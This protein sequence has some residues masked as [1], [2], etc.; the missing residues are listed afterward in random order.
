MAPIMPGPNLAWDGSV[1]ATGARVGERDVGRVELPAPAVL[2]Q[3]E[4][5]D[6]VGKR[7]PDAAVRQRVLELP[8]LGAAGADDELHDPA[9]IVGVAGR[10][11]RR[12][13]LVIVIVA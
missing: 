11:L 4:L 8:Q 5:D 3:P 10:V 2:V 9:L 1:A 12:E 6:A 7:R 13:P